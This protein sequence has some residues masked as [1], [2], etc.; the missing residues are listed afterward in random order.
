METDED[1][2]VPT[3]A[4]EGLN[5]ATRKARLA[6]D[7]VVVRDGK[8]VKIKQSQTVEVLGVVPGRH[9]VSVRVKRIKQ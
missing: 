3:L 2:D 9:K 8:L 6:G 7:I 5:E 1:A 4:V